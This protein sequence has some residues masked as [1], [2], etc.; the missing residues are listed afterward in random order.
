MSPQFK[1]EAVQ[2]VIE[3]GRIIAEIVR[4]LEINDGTLGNWVNE[5]KNN[6]REPR[7]PWNRW[8]VAEMGDEIRRLRLENA[9]RG[10]AAAFGSAK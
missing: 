10:R 1:A 7:R 4:E 5:R 6:N 3:S 2:F 9:F 8:S